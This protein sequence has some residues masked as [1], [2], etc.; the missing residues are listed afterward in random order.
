MRE[1]Y[2]ENRNNN[3]ISGNW[4]YISLIIGIEGMTGEFIYRQFLKLIRSTEIDDWLNQNTNINAHD[5][6]SFLNL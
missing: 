4:G 2:K 1:I 6:K 3:I 5:F